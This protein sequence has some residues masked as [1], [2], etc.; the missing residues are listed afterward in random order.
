MSV[1]KKVELGK[2]LTNDEYL[3][4]R[5]D[6]V[7]GLLVSY[8]YL[9]LGYVSQGDDQTKQP[10]LVVQ[11]QFGCQKDENGECFDCGHT[12]EVDP[13]VCE[14]GCQVKSPEKGCYSFWAKGM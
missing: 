10:G 8:L 2:C 9:H 11:Y 13:A 7:D 6:V 3:A 5:L 12:G 4:Y 14:W 1:D